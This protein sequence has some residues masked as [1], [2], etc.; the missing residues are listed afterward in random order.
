MSLLDAFIGVLSPRDHGTA[1]CLAGTLVQEV[2]ET[3]AAIR[4]AVRDSFAELQAAI[5]AFIRDAAGGRAVEADEL[6]RL[7]ITTIQGGLILVKASRDPTVLP[8]SLRHVREYIR[9]RVTGA[10]A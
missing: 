3:N 1:S 6:A 8:E 4:E 7:W 2:S 5:A 10:P 9:S